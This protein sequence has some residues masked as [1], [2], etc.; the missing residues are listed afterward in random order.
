MGR[1]IK[2]QAIYSMDYFA[3]SVL[4][5][6]RHEHIRKAIYRTQHGRVSHLPGS[7]PGEPGSVAALVDVDGSLRMRKLPPDGAGESCCK[8]WRA[9]DYRELMKVA[10]KSM[11]FRFRA[12]RNFGTG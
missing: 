9:A 8:P 4:A 7:R 5:V 1:A 6:L 2:P 3:S 12:R 10:V 11:C